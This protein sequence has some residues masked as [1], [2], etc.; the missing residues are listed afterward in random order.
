MEFFLMSFYG[1]AA[2]S[3]VLFRSLSLS[4]YNG[5]RQLSLTIAGFTQ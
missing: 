4:P 1:F 5:V 3:Y 2:L